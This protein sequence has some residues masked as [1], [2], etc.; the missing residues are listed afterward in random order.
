MSEDVGRAVAELASRHD[1]PVALIL[2]EEIMEELLE[3]RKEE[4]GVRA[5]TRSVIV[6]DQVVE[7]VYTLL[8][9]AGRG[10]VREAVI[11]TDSPD[12]TIYIEVDGKPYI[13]HGF[14]ELLGL[15]DVI[16]SVDVFD[17]DGTYVVR[18][19]DIAFLEGCNIYLRPH[20]RL[21]V[22]HALV[23]YDVF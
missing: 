19:S 21:V 5:S 6:R 7:G 9:V 11:V 12:L 3:G 18:T 14:T 17:K 10:K 13:N 16:R 23:L 20:R 22:K 15:S 4:G 8:S 1:L 2:A